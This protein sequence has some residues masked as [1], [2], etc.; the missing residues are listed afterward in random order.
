MKNATACALLALACLVPHAHATNAPAEVQAELPQAS[1]SGQATMTVWGFQVYQAALWVAPDFVDTRYAQS[2]FALELTYLRDF[3]GADIAKRSI[4]EMRRQTTLSADLQAR[5]EASMQA[6]FP[7]VQ[8]GDRITGLHHPG[9]GAKFWRNG[10]LLG[11]IGDGQFAKLFFG[12]WL[13]PQTSEPALRRALLSPLH[14]AAG[15]GRQP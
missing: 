3:K 10:Q 6:I 8:A 12:I 7:D 9:R 5:W 15:I 14:T 13:S 1:L 4:A 2:S 11:E